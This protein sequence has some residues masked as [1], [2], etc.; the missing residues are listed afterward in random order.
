MRLSLSII[1]FPLEDFSSEKKKV[2]EVAPSWR[3]L[4]S[5]VKVLGSMSKRTNLALF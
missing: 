2:P 4:A 5:M 3:T 1:Q